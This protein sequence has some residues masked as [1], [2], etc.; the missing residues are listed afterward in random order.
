[1]KV[2][3]TRR[4]LKCGLRIHSHLIRPEHHIFVSSA[5]VVVSIA[6]DQ[7]WSYSDYTEVCRTIRTAQHAFHLFHIEELGGPLRATMVRFGLLG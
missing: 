4:L 1:M 6:I 3:F 2:H 5:R 7:G